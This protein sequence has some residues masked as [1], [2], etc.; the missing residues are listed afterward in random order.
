[1]IPTDDS[2]NLVLLW[3][4]FEVGVV[5]YTLNYTRNNDFLCLIIDLKLVSYS[6]TV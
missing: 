3:W 1:M 4:S 6:V 5:V 2:G